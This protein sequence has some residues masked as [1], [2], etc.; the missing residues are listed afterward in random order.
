[1]H[2]PA[3]CLAGALAGAG[4]CPRDA[5]RVLGRAALPARPSLRGPRRR[6]W[7]PRSAFLRALSGSRP[8]RACR[9][10]P[11]QPPDHEQL[12]IERCSSWDGARARARPP[13]VPASAWTCEAKA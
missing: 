12:G 9:P 4:G 1:M 3:A 10:T 5:V 2:A 11:F 13:T 6:L 8:V 7:P